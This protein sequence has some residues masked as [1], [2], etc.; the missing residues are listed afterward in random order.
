MFGKA[1]DSVEQGG[2]AGYRFAVVVSV[3][4]SRVEVPPVVDDGDEVGHQAAGGE[5]L[6]DVAGPAPLVFEFVIDVF[7]VGSFAVEPRHG[8]GGVGDGVEAGDEGCDFAAPGGGGALP[9]V[10]AGE[11]GL[12]V[13]ASPPGVVPDGGDGGGFAD[14]DDSPFAAP[15]AELEGGFDGLPAV[16]GVDPYGSGAL[17]LLDEGFD[18]EG[19]FEFEKVREFEGFGGAHDSGICVDAK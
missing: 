3:E 19:V 13:V 15:A 10:T 16:S 12:V 1:G 9:V 18:F 2:A 8:D 17:H 4:H 7:G 14:E 6:G 5:F 11:G